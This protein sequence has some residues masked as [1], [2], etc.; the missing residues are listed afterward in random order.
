[1]EVKMKKKKSYKNYKRNLSCSG[2]KKM[3]GSLFGKAGRTCLKKKPFKK[4]RIY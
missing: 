3:V 1:M 4:R 2:A